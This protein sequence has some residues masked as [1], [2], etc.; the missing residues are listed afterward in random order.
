MA[1]PIIAGLA[2]VIIKVKQELKKRKE[3][4]ALRKQEQDEAST[5]ASQMVDDG[6][7][8]VGSISHSVEKL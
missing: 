3:R 2:I 4:K 5:A 6:K 8:E 7:T 1:A